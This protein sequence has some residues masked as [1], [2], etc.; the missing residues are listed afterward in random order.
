MWRPCSSCAR[1]RVISRV[2]LAGS[3]ADWRSVR[4]SASAPRS[5]WA[6]VWRP[7]R[8]SCPILCSRRSPASLSLWGSIFL[9]AG[10]TTRRVEAVRT[11]EVRTTRPASSRHPATVRPRLGTVART[12]DVRP[13]RRDTPTRGTTVQVAHRMPVSA[14]QPNRRCPTLPASSGHLSCP[15]RPPAPASR[16]SKARRIRAR[17]LPIRGPRLD[18]R[19]EAHAE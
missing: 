16:V 18:R 10:R 7:R 13:P 5:S 11:R 14:R 1:R 8:A 17:P 12:Q 4:R 15:V 3:V 9:A 19:E 6:R 2:T